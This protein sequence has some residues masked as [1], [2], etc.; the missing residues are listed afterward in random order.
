[1]F[2]EETWR[3]LLHL[4]EPL[5]PRG[6]V[7]DCVRVCDVYSRGLYSRAYPKS[8]SAGNLQDSTLTSAC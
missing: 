8:Q 7:T 4:T 5:H 1:M 2:L 6:A 3:F